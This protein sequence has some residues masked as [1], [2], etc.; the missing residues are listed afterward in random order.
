MGK[1]L[2]I[3]FT[4]R[5]Y[6]LG[7]LGLAAFTDS[8][9]ENRRQLSGSSL[10]LREA[11]GGTLIA[12]STSGSLYVIAADGDHVIP[13]PLPSPIA[14]EASPR[15]PYLIESFA[16]RLLIWNLDDLQPRA[17]TASVPAFTGFA[18]N[19]RV[20]AS[21]LGAPAHWI[22]LGGATPIDTATESLGPISALA[23]STDG[24][25]AVIVDVAHHARLMAPG[26]AAS[27][28]L[29]GEIDR[30]GFLDATHVLVGGAGG[31]AIHDLASGAR[32]ALAT[33]AGTFDYF[34]WT[35]SAPRWIAASAG[36]TLWRHGTADATVPLAQKPTS[37]PIVL[38]DGTVLV[39][40]GKQLWVW[41]AGGALA[42]LATL[43]RPIA[44]LAPGDAAQ[45]IAFDAT[46]MTYL[47]ELATGQIRSFY[48]L[49]ASAAMAADGGLVVTVD[50]TGN[51]EVV[52][53]LTRQH[54]ILAEASGATFA[55][56]RISPDGNRIVATT[57][58]HAIVFTLDLPVDEAATTAWLDRLTNAH[59]EPDSSLTW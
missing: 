49:G 43:P 30:A 39:G 21:Y 6:S 44:D 7:T 38:A 47:V 10:G 15:S 25:H 41:R 18:G 35:R 34:A 36:A 14:I 32:V 17:I 48:E 53:P 33:P 31:L 4:D 50:R 26:A 59:A 3:A 57:T 23:A 5:M 19:D 9:P 51:L 22:D 54:W 1:R 56:P 2:G 20:L 58:D 40:I 55:F 42:V 52:D 27:V 16:G 11:R 13:V 46:G 45:A 37:P 24:S 8:D 28:A 29:A 12:A